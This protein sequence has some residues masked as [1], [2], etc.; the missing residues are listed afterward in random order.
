MKNKGVFLLW[1]GSIVLMGLCFGGPSFGA[2][3]NLVFATQTDI[4]SV[5]PHQASGHLSMMGVNPFYDTLVTLKAGTTEL[6]PSLAESWDVSPDGMVITFKLRRNV[7]FHDGRPLTAE[8]VKFTFAR[9]LKAKVTGPSALLEKKT[10]EDMMEALD[11]H[12]FR[13]KL[14]QKS[15]V[16]FGTLTAPWFG[17]MSKD[18]VTKN[19]TKEDPL[20]LKWMYN[21]ECGTGPW[22]LAQWIPNEKLV[23]NALEGTGGITPNAPWFRK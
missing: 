21:H 15:P 17:I 19:A 4:I 9:L 6:C 7:K 10:A 16:I 5:D 2:E 12:T 11:A 1:L 14:H 8:D 22:E 23:Y 13:M 3:K 18:Y 20:A